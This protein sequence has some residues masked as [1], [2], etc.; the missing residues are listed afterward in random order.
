MTALSVKLGLGNEYIRREDSPGIA[1]G[2]NPRISLLSDL[3]NCSEDPEA[4]L[5][6]N[7]KDQVNRRAPQNGALAH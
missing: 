1:D 5:R 6:L 4:I 2:A 3:V 7:A